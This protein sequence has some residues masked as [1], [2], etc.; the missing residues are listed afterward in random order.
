MSDEREAQSV[1][2][3]PSMGDILVEKEAKKY[4]ASEQKYYRNQWLA[5]A[6]KIE[7]CGKRRA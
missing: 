4:M 5:P 1:K 2:R 6:L 3:E 7:A